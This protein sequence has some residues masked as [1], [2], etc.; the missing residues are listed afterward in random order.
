MRDDK[1][2]FCKIIAG[3]IPSNTIYEDDDFKAMLD[4][5]PATKGHTLIIPKNHY[6]N[7]MELDDEAASKALLVA[8]KIA[9]KMMGSLGCDG[10]NMAQNNGIVAGQTVNHFH[11]H[12]IPRY[13]ND[14]DKTICGWSHQSFTADEMAEIKNTLSF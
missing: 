12:L 3:E 10:I 9:T 1:C 5:D 4:I 6:A 14:K 13:K 2:I 8:K 11:I 7:L